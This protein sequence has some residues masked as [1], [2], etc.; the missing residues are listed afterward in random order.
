MMNVSNIPEKPKLIRSTH[1]HKDINNG[2]TVISA[3]N[4]DALLAEFVV[5]PNNSKEEEVQLLNYY[6]SG[7]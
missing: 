4:Y 1:I 6:I 2:K 7:K 3:V 5:N